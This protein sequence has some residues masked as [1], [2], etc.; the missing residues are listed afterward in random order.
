MLRG[1]FETRASVSGRRDPGRPDSAARTTCRRSAGRHHFSEGT[2]WA[3]AWG[4]ALGASRRRCSNHGNGF[5]VVVGCRLRARYRRPGQD[6]AG[7]GSTEGPGASLG[8]NPRR[9]GMW[10]SFWRGGSASGHL[11]LCRRQVRSQ[12]RQV[13]SGVRSGVRSCGRAFSPHPRE[14]SWGERRRV[15][16]GSLPPGESPTA[17]RELTAACPPRGRRAVGD[18]GQGGGRRLSSAQ[19]RSCSTSRAS[20]PQQHAVATAAW[21]GGAGSPASCVKRSAIRAVSF[22]GCS[23]SP[24]HGRWRGAPAPAGRRS[25]GGSSGAARAD[26]RDGPLGPVVEDGASKRPGAR[27]AGVLLHADRRQLPGPRV[28]RCAVTRAWRCGLSE[29]VAAQKLARPPGKVPPPPK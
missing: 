25:G 1:R 7:G 12:A 17:P 26:D 10:V 28:G 19:W 13:R 27:H 9:A 23:S 5:E 24:A 4:G 22:S 29:G 2:P 15:L 6:A 3:T 14:L 20:S 18:Q 21:S 16:L 11:A 8:A